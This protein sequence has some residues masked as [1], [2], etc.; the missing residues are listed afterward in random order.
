M[1]INCPRKFIVGNGSHAEI[2]E[3]RTG[4]SLDRQVVPAS[5]SEHGDIFGHRGSR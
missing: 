3:R 4:G 1:A 2:S 5:G